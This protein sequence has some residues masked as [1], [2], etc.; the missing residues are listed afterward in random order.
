MLCEWEVSNIISCRTG[1]QKHNGRLKLIFITS[2]EILTKWEI[3]LNV[4]LLYKGDTIYSH[5]INKI[6]L[7]NKYMYLLNTIKTKWNLWWPT[8]Q[9]SFVAFSRWGIK[10]P[11]SFLRIKYPEDLVI[12]SELSCVEIRR[13]LI[14]DSRSITNENNIIVSKYQHAPTSD[15]RTVSQHSLCSSLPFS[16]TLFLSISFSLSHM[17]FL[18]LSHSPPL[19]LYLSIILQLQWYLFIRIM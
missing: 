17:L 7:E 5:R 14:K 11:V 1:E 19:S 6:R 10:Y 4:P 15:P 8:L 18:S 9:F 3:S 16:F 12:L 2:D 13:Q